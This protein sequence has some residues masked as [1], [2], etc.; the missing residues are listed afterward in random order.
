MEK[1]QDLGTGQIR[2]LHP[3][4]PLIA[5][6]GKLHSTLSLSFLLRKMEVRSQFLSQKYQQGDRSATH[7]SFPQALGGDLDAHQTLL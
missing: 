5:N 2:P 6:L 1:A 4:M 3:G 7:S